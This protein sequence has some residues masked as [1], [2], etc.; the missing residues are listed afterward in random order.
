MSATPSSR[1][2]IVRLTTIGGST[3]SLW[4]THSIQAPASINGSRLVGQN[5]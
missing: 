5:F 2:G 3:S 1:L 4:A